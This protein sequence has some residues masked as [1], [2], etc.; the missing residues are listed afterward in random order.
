MPS[1]F[2]RNPEYKNTPVPRSTIRN[3]T[4][5]NNY[6]RPTN[7]LATN[8]NATRRMKIKQNRK[9]VEEQNLI[10]RV[11]VM[12]RN[13]RKAKN[14][15]PFDNYVKILKANKISDLES[16]GINASSKEDNLK[17]YKI[18][19]LNELFTLFMVIIGEILNF[20][21]N[22]DL[23]E[24]KG[25]IDNPSLARIEQGRTGEIAFNLLWGF[26]MLATR[27][28]GGSRSMTGGSL[29][30]AFAAILAAIGVV[31]VS[32]PFIAVFQCYVYYNN[33]RQEINFMQLLMLTYKTFFSSNNAIEYKNEINYYQLNQEQKDFFYEKADTFKNVDI[34]N[35]TD[36][37]AFKTF[38]IEF[39]NLKLREV[40]PNE[41]PSASAG[42]ESASAAG[43]SA[44]GPSA[45]G[46]SAAGTGLR[47]NISTLPVRSFLLPTPLRSTPLGP[48]PAYYGMRPKTASSLGPTPGKVRIN[49]SKTASVK[50]ILAGYEAK[51]KL[52]QQS[53]TSRMADVESIKL[54]PRNTAMFLN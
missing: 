11:Q 39:I 52:G 17:N 15:I 14:A 50:E 40:A 28:S 10:R 19:V 35:K 31:I 9:N 42:P 45:A 27:P 6:R 7:F 48:S 54:S 5:K 16:I 43:P 1:L 38:L 47:S 53:A 36:T 26:F 46:P 44:A 23:Q 13:A 37:D 51:L 4:I 18:L 25:K 21:I 32:I 30:L 33:K 29:S 3:Y 24:L 34:N 8:N 2:P 49:T 41:G 20:T 22:G 12:V